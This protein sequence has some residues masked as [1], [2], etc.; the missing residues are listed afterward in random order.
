MSIT[1]PNL[2]DR[3]YADLVEEARDLLVAHAPALTDHNPSDPGVT[4]VELFAYFT[5]VLL[6]RANTVT[7]A[8]RVKFLRLLNGPDWPIPGSPQELDAQIR[9]TVLELRR[10]DRAVTAAD[11][12]FLARASDPAA[13]I[14]RAHCIPERNLDATDPVARRQPQPSHVS[15]VI[16]PFESADLP[17]LRDLAAA[18]LAPRRLLTTQVHVVGPRRVPIRFRAT[19]RL[20]PDAVK[21]DVHASAVA[22]LTQFLDPIL[23]GG[24]GSG[25]PFGRNV[26]VSEI[27]RLLDALPG[28]DFVRRTLDQTSS[29]PLDELVTTQ[30]FADRAMRNSQGE[31]ISIALDPDD[32]PEYQST[33]AG[34]DIAIELPPM[35]F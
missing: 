16:V 28:V 1:L 27:Y 17:V 6:F 5:E 30:P 15:V 25:W 11:F 19:L 12:E 21:D 29:T 13:R 22:A 26:Y 23:G 14:A 33:T 4:L 2:D 35:S 7:T 9:N 10:T 24:D 32:L 20:L 34:A 8:S 31:L 3:R 18:Y